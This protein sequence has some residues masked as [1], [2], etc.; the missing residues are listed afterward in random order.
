ML[1]RGDLNASSSST[2]VD[3]A[4]K[5]ARQLCGLSKD[6][7]IFY[8]RCI[9]RFS[10]IDILH[11]DSSSR[12]NT[13]VAAVDDGVLILMNLSSDPILPGWPVGTPRTTSR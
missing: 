6:A 1:C 7:T 13:S 2:C 8:D 9:I 11:M 10:D 12:V 4:F 5:D 3:A